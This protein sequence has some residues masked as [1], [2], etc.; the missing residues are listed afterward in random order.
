MAL[1]ALAA[2]R[3]SAALTSTGGIVAEEE[4]DDDDV[5]E[6]AV[7]TFVDGATSASAPRSTGFCAIW[8]CISSS[9]SSSSS[10]PVRRMGASML[11][12]DGLGEK[13]ANHTALHPS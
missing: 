5:A 11:A 8:G 12:N 6:S 1:T 10:A 7:E 4:D 13:C 9:S 3:L 2:S